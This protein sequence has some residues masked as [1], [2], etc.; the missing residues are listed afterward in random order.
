MKKIFE[1]WKSKRQL[2]EENIRLQALLSMP[3]QIHTVERNVMPYTVSCILEENMPIE[4]ARNKI[5]KLLGQGLLDNELI[6]WNIIDETDAGR[7][8]HTLIGK[9]YIVRR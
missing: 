9:I 1:N 3:T 7:F 4:F 2:R 5:S 6:E 8:A